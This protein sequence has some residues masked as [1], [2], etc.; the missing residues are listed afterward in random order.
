ME[1]LHINFCFI[2]LL[3][4]V[5]Y[6]VESGCWKGGEQREGRKKKKKEKQSKG[7]QCN[8]RDELWADTLRLWCSELGRSSVYHQQLC[9][10]ESL[11]WL[12]T[13]KMAPSLLVP[14]R[15]LEDK[16]LLTPGNIAFCCIISHG[17]VWPRTFSGVWQWQESRTFVIRCS[18]HWDLSCFINTQQFVKY[19]QI[20][21]HTHIHSSPPP[22]SFFLTD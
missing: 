19:K 12:P 10:C 21:I 8:P 20:T 9:L 22:S 2:L 14:P 3:H 11:V 5:T 18:C 16:F 13:Q 6:E 4:E 17:W 7:P 15:H 1:N